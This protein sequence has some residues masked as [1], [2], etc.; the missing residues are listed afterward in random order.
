MKQ[1]MTLDEQKKTYNRMLCIIPA[2][3]LFMVG[4]Y[5]MGIEPK[6]STTVSGMISSGWLTIADWRIA[7]IIMNL[8]Q[9][10]VYNNI[11]IGRPYPKR[12]MPSSL[13][14]GT[15]TRLYL[16]TVRVKLQ[17]LL[18]QIWQWHLILVG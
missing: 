7:F 2:M 3:L 1:F 4:D 12:W 9:D 11:A 10:T 15:D 18:S 8:F 14:T 17:I 16:H 5:C 6:D 13:P